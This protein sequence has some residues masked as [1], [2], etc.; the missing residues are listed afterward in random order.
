MVFH[1][2]CVVVSTTDFHAPVQ[3]RL[4][5]VHFAGV[6]LLL[7]FQVG[8]VHVGVGIY[9]VKIHPLHCD[10]AALTVTDFADTRVGPVSL[11]SGVANTAVQQDIDLHILR[12]DCFLHI[13]EFYQVTGFEVVV[14]RHVDEDAPCVV[15]RHVGI[16]QTLCDHGIL[17]V[18]VIVRRIHGQEVISGRQSCQTDLGTGP[19]LK[20]SVVRILQ[21]IRH[22]VFPVAAIVRQDDLAPFPAH[23]IQ[24]DFERV[25]TRFVLLH[26]LRDGETGDRL[27][28]A[29]RDRLHALVAVRR[30]QARIRDVPVQRVV[31]LH[32]VVAI[33]ADVVIPDCES[34]QGNRIL[35]FRSPGIS[36]HISVGVQDFDIQVAHAD[37]VGNADPVVRRAFFEDGE[38]VV[39]DVRIAVD[40]EAVDA[41]FSVRSMEICCSFKIIVVAAF[42]MFVRLDILF[43][44]IERQIV[45]RDGDAVFADDLRHIDAVL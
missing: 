14:A 6:P 38:F 35:V 45:V 10:C 15:L 5:R 12:Q 20:N 21:H 28:F 39:V 29:N 16:R 8:R 13:Q 1:D 27:V 42:F 31:V 2:Q 19:A 40:G 22:P 3:E 4:K 32:I 34:L 25:G 7:E 30:N 17:A 33:D 43:P 36:G 41:V 11:G 24:R 23:V 18:L 44:D 37:L 26:R 9:A